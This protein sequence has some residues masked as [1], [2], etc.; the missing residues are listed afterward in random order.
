VKVKDLIAALEK[1]DQPELPVWVWLPDL[2]IEPTS[3]A[4]LQGGALIEGNVVRGE[5]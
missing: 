1:L 5:R 2:Y 3:V 4:L